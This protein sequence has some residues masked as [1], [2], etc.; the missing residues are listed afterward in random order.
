M[1]WEYSLCE[2]CKYFKRK[3][4]MRKVK[5]RVGKK[6]VEIWVCDFYGATKSL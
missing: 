1:N 3:S 2:N 6:E 4:K 5:F